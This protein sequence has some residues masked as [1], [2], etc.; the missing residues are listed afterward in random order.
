MGINVRDMSI[1]ESRCVV[2]GVHS[3]ANSRP[4]A[5]TAP[6]EVSPSKYVQAADTDTQMHAAN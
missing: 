4:E 2:V 6:G 3:A 5:E 1:E